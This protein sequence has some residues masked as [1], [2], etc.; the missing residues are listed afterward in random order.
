MVQIAILSLWN[1]VQQEKP[2]SPIKTTDSA[3]KKYKM[4]VRIFKKLEH[5]TVHSST[6]YKSQVME[7]T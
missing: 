7:A 1:Q 3:N 2:V 6:I 5:P 4:H